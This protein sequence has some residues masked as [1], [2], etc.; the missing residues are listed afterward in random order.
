LLDATRRLLRRG[1]VSRELGSEARV[2]VEQ[3]LSRLGAAMHAD[4]F[5]V[6]EFDE[7]HEAALNLSTK[8]LARW[9]A[10]LA[11]EYFESIFI[12]VAVALLLRAFLVEAFKIPSGSMLPT[13]QIN[14]HIFVNKLSYGPKLPFTKTRVLSS[15]PPDRGDIVVFEFP[16]PN[17]DNARQDY[18]KRV[19][20]LPGDTLEVSDGHPIIN[21]FQVPSCR[22]GT[23]SF[24]DDMGYRQSGELFVEFLGDESYLTFYDRDG[25]NRSRQGPYHVQEGEFWV[26]GDNRNNSSDSRAW[27]H[28]RGA[29]VPFD[30]VKGRAL[31]VWLSFNGANGGPFGITWDRLFTNVMGTPRL[32]KEA[33]P[34]LKQGID[35][36]LA[37]RPNETM[38]PAPSGHH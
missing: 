17:P 3:A 28:M 33:L 24:N 36:C 12:A 2:E 5:S 25:A 9:Q 32:P 15:M 18:I 1:I 38:P 26:L 34:E 7:A 6:A 35:R 16:D 23:Y 8:H 30:N 37:E 21:G 27:R 31:F 4:E 10:N 14:D 19:I 13:L 11:R 22:V 29:G 20:A